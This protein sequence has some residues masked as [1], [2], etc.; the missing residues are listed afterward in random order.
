MNDN[1]VKPVLGMYRTQVLT[2]CLHG[3]PDC[4]LFPERTEPA[5]ALKR[6]Q[7][8]PG[9]LCA[10]DKATVPPDHRAAPHHSHQD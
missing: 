8:K 2:A 10:T 3:P 7:K 4:Q 1:H 5:S 6:R 9:G